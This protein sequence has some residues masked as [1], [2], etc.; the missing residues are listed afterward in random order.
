M[1]KPVWR[2]LRWVS[3]VLTG[4]LFDRSLATAGSIVSLT[5]ALI[6]ISAGAAA[7]IVPPT[8]DPGQLDRRFSV[9]ETPRSGP[10]RT[11]PAPLDQPEPRVGGD[12]RFQVSRIVIE[13]LSVVSPSISTI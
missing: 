3:A 12:L 5:L 11:I 2:T 9:P 13:G 6:A 10:S 4:G 7:Q 8:A 1:T